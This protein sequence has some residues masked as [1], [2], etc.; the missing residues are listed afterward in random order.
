MQFVKYVVTGCILL[1]AFLISTPYSF[2][3]TQENAV[4]PATE[5][6]TAEPVAAE[7]AT[8]EAAAEEPVIGEPVVSGEEQEAE[9]EHSPW[10]GG[11]GRH[12]GL[13]L[14]LSVGAGYSYFSA[15][16][17]DPTT[18]RDTDLT[19]SG[20]AVIPEAAI[21][22]YVMENLDLHLAVKVP[23]NVEPDLELDVDPA[24]AATINEA[25][26]IEYRALMIG[27][28]FTYYFMPINMFIG[29]TGNVLVPQFRLNESDL[30]KAANNAVTDY[31][32]GGSAELHFGKEWRM[33]DFASLGLEVM[34]IFSAYPGDDA[35]WYGHTAG[36]L[37]TATYN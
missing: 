15:T 36:V 31:K 18:G 28:G 13:H 2:A 27:A 37:F 24:D 8:E 19:M 35:S 29:A 22:Y 17:S 6:A 3:Q 25:G 26:D 32:I 21:G 16:Y 4:E 23:V 7:P 14:R 34:Y 5:P 9:A 11:R 12:E 30:S 20:A 1:V 33:D 10:L